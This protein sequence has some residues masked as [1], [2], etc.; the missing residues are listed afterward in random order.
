MEKIDK[1][2]S[3]KN[4]HSIYMTKDLDQEYVVLN[5]KI[6]AFLHIQQ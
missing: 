1:P 4:I 5:L 2:Q 3:G 6:C